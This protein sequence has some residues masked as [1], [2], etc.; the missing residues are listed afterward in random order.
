MKYLKYILG[1]LAILFIGFLLLGLIKPELSYECEITVEKP[2]AEAW[3]AAQDEE[4]LADWLPGLQ[5]IEH[6]SGTPGTVGAVSD[7]YFDNNGQ[8]VIIRETITD[9]VPNTSI[10][11]TYESDFMNMEYTLSMTDID[12]KTKINSSTTTVGNGMFSKSLMAL[13]GGS[14]KAQEETNLANL[15]KTIEENTKDYAPAKELA[16]EVIQE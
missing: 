4:K 3:A 13:M 2:L 16:T 15:K 11:M 8:Q 5:K 1:I 10:S 9:I 6:I 7:V 12:G 14:I